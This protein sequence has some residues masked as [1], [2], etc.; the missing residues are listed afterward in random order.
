MKRSS[1]LLVGIILV[2]FVMAS[3]QDAPQTSRPMLT[4]NLRAMPNPADPDPESQSPEERNATLQKRM[5]AAKDLLDAGNV[6][7]WLNEYFDPFPAA[8]GASKTEFTIDE[9]FE[10]ILSDKARATRFITQH[11][12]AI[13]Q[14]LDKEPKWLLNGRAASFISEEHP[15]SPANFW[16]YFDGKWRLSPSP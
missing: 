2:T 14:T 11:S 10:K 13:G 15:R 3:A 16:I 9:L 8:R 4:F 7:E 1:Y 6:H 12:E 5:R